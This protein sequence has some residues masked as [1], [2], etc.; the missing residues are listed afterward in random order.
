MKE[1]SETIKQNLQ[2]VTDEFEKEDTEVRYRQ[3]RLWKKLKLYWEGYHRVWYDEVAHDWKIF[4]SVND[5]GDSD[6]AYYDKPINVF[7]AYLESIIAALSITVPA[8]KCVPD[9][10]D[11]PLDLSTAKA[12]D[13][14][15]ELVYK[16]ND[17][18]LLWLHALY[19][20]LTEGMIAAY[21]YTKEDEKYGTYEV[22]EYEENIREA[23]KCPNC[24]AELPD[25]TFADLGDQAEIA[26]EFMC[27]ECGENLD[28]SMPKSSFTVTTLVGVNKLP[29]SRQ[30]IEIYGGL[31]VKVPNYA[32]SQADCPYLMF[33]YETNYVDVIEK[34]PHLEDDKKISTG[35]GMGNDDYASWGRLSSQYRGDQPN[36]TVTVR[37]AWLRP[38]AFN[39]LDKDSREELKKEFPKGVKVVLVNNVFAEACEEELD[40]HWTI[41]KHPLSDYIHHDPLGAILTPIQDITNDLTAL[42]L[43]TIEQGIPQTFA[44]P[45]ILNFDEYRQ[46]EATPGSVYPTKAVAPNKNISEGFFTLKAS[47]L[48]G[49]VLP[50]AEKVQSMGQLVSGALPSLFGGSAQAGSQT[51]SE[52]AM[53]RAQAQQRLQ[54]QWKMLL[55]WWKNIFGK[56]I[57]AYIECVMEDERYVEKNKDSGSYV[58]TFI[59]KAELEG[60]I[61]EIELEASD[62]LPLTWAQKKE[63]IMALMQINNPAILEALAAPENI[64]Y[65]KDIVGI[66][67]FVLPGEADRQKQYEEIKMLV[68]SEPIIDLDP[69]TGMPVEQPSVGVDSV[70]DNHAVE[71]DICRRWLISEVGRQAKVDNEAGYKNV[72]LHMQAHMTVIAQQMMQQQQQEMAMAE[73]ANVGGGEKPQKKTK[74]P[75]QIEGENDSR[76]PVQ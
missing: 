37:S 27:P 14:I 39:V 69:M 40:A 35:K 66:P 74:Q 75:T 43:Q 52:Y 20:L 24:E 57:P 16:H 26:P 29:K 28:P 59:R 10:A 7:R 8:I 31:Y 73:A 64:P 53:S 6:A 13:K 2:K 67:E 55:Y 18:P 38:C 23:Y 68:A 65:L 56:V 51:A 34:Y 45:A 50:F 4:D 11:N 49:E 76:L 17:A 1:L 3:I 9:D 32:K 30:I 48:S 61:G 72:L 36:N 25:T 33:S 42:T 60:K 19:I 22:P 44:D 46:A 62:Q 15:A 54:T 63:A 71:A 70:I 58:N 21:N 41:T 47:N 12:G 5:S